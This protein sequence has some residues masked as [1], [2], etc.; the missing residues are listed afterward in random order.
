MNFFRSEEHITRWLVGRD[1]GLS[2][3][4]TKLSELAHTWWGDRVAATWRPHTREQNQEILTRLD[5]TDAFWQ[6]A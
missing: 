1:R 6:L 3:S 2:I 5:L 4:I